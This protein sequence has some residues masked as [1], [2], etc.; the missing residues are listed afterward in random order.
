MN[1]DD[2]IRMV[3]EAEIVATNAPSSTIERFATLVA[4]H[5]REKCIEAC[6]DVWQKEGD[7]GNIQMNVLKCIEALRARGQ[8]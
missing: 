8:S 5:E 3:K 1:R 2:I 4:N 7:K 6:Q